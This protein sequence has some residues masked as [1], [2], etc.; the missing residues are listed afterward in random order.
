MRSGRASEPGAGRWTCSPARAYS[1]ESGESAGAFLNL[2]VQFANLEGVVVPLAP[3]KRAS[4]DEFSAQD[5][6]LLPGQPEEVLAILRDRAL[7]P[8]A[9]EAG[10]DVGRIVGIN[11]DGD[12]ATTT[13]ALIERFVL[14]AHVLDLDS[15][16]RINGGARVSWR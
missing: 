13:I 11:L 1:F 12:L 16:S 3:C 2:P 8:L 4:L 9:L 5:P 7:E 15:V 10:P 14:V 6:N